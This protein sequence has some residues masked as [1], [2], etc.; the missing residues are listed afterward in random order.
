MAHFLVKSVVVD[1]QLPQTFQVHFLPYHFLKTVEVFFMLHIQLNARGGKRKSILALMPIEVG[2]VQSVHEIV[3]N[4]PQGICDCGFVITG[5]FRISET[6]K[7]VRH[8]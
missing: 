3:A 7:I 2:W 1:E 4:T 5:L 6:K 8:G